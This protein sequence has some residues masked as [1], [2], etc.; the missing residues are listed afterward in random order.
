MNIYMRLKD[1]LKSRKTFKEEM[2]W[3]YIGKH[4]YRGCDR[5]VGSGYFSEVMKPGFPQKIRGHT[6]AVKM[7]KRE[8]SG[9]FFEILQ[10]PEYVLI[11]G[12]SMMID[13]IFLTLFRSLAKRTPHL[14]QMLE[15]SK[16]EGFYKLFL[17][18]CGLHEPME[19]PL[20]RKYQ[21]LNNIHSTLEQVSL[22]LNN[23]QD[24]LYYPQVMTMMNLDLTLLVDSVTVAFLHTTW[25]L[26]SR[27][28]ITLFDQ[29]PRNLMLKW[30]RKAPKKVYYQIDKE[31][32]LMV[33]T[34]GIIVK[35]G[36]VSLAV[37][38]GDQVVVHGATH[39][40][41]IT[42]H[43]VGKWHPSFLH[44][45]QTIHEM[46]PQLDTALRRLFSSTKVPNT[47]D[48]LDA[49]TLAKLPKQLQLL[50]SKKLFGKFR[51]P[52]PPRINQDE[53][54]VRL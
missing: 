37:Y 38:N 35:L 30:D 26:W 18:Y 11:R 36:D 42:P 45:L 20:G 43:A 40:E 13:V 52:I 2:L 1:I 44:Y 17:E 4:E 12:Q 25:L 8:S 41:D 51:A 50:R 32:C 7:E 54:I 14:L 33:P 15:Y 16:C 5:Y 53:M 22:Y 34:Q 10:E 3:D 6:V 31:T 29:Y 23:L 28:G 39:R 21:H 9:K 48:L 19:L 24:I 27:L 47:N 49:D 46:Q